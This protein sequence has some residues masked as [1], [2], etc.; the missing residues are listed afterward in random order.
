MS[1]MAGIDMSMVPKIIVFTLI[2]RFSSQ[3]GS[4]NVKN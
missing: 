1:V 3:R 4:A 2:I